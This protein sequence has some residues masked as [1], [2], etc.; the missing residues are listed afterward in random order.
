M[1]PPGGKD[2]KL[3]IYGLEAQGDEVDADVF[4]AKLKKVVSALRRLDTFYNVKG[5]HRFMINNMEFRSA[6]VWLREKQI[7]SRRVRRSP[8]RRFAEIGAQA[9]A[10]GDVGVDNAADEYALSSYEGLSKG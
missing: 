9:A 6:T 7:K 8:T 5:H 3:T 10:G 4:A 2:L 1:A